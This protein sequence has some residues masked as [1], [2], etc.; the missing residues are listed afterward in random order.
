MIEKKYF[1]ELAQLYEEVD[2]ILLINPKEVFGLNRFYAIN[3]LYPLIYDPLF[4]PKNILCGVKHSLG[5]EDDEVRPNFPK[6]FDQEKNRKKRLIISPFATSCTPCMSNEDWLVIAQLAKRKGFEVFFNAP[7]GVFDGFECDLL[8]IKEFLSFC[9][10]STHFIG[11]RSGLCDVVA[12]FTPI[13]M[14]IVYPN[15]RKKSE[16]N[17]IKDYDLDPNNKY[18]QFCSLKQIFSDRGNIEE[19]I[20]DKDSFALFLED[21]L[22]G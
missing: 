13:K 11:Y 20:F 16:F 12:S 2:G 1:G 6:I 9:S 3:I 10:E 14:L 22:N 17:C 15:N 5:L 8:P 21:F 18:L 7:K 4:L 19:F